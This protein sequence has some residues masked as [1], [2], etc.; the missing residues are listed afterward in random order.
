MASSA[1]LD[2]APALS[3]CLNHT[4]EIPASDLNDTGRIVHTSL[5]NRRVIRT[6]DLPDGRVVVDA[7]LLRLTGIER[8]VL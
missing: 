3:A 1:C 6:I 8:A 2:Y 5:R 7:V 4:S